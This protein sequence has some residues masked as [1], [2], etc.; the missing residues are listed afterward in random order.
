MTRHCRLPLL[1]IFVFGGFTT[2]LVAAAQAGA[3]CEPRSSMVATLASEY[4]ETRRGVGLAGPTAVFEVWASA[5]TGSW[6]ILKTTPD[7]LACVM[8]VGDGWQNF[9]P[10]TDTGA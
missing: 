8:A 7:G 3:A 5:D 6:T 10:V 2:Y 9:A 4:G 1:A